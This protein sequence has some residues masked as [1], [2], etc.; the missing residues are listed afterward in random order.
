MYEE[1]LEEFK[2]EKSLPKDYLIYEESLIEIA[3]A[4]TV[5][6]KDALQKLQEL[7]ER[8]KEEYISPYE[9]ACAYF[10]LGEINQGFSWMEKAYEEHDQGLLYIKIAPDLDSVRTDPRFKALLKKMG[11]E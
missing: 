5:K 4:R 10:R 6:G 8:T 7:I 2:K 1:A 11:L 9:L 3:Y